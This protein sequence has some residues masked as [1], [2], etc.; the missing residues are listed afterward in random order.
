MGG[1]SQQACFYNTQPALSS[2]NCVAHCAVYVWHT[3]YHLPAPC[4]PAPC[5]F[6]PC[7]QAEAELLAAMTLFF[8]RVGLT[9]KDVGIK[10]SSR[11][12]GPWWG[13]GGQGSHVVTNSTHK[14]PEGFR[15]C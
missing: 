5:P 10:L 6:S 8:E 15:V 14:R 1:F 11:K 13:Q 4:P 2:G 3:A 12:V 7:P 9:P